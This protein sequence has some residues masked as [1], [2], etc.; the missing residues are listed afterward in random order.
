MIRAGAIGGACLLCL[1]SIGLVQGCSADP[2]RGYSF[3]SAHSDSIRTVAV[4]VFKNVTYSKTLEVQLTEAIISEIRRTTPWSVTSPE[5]ADA[6][7]TGTL[8]ES[9]MRAMS[10]G[11]QTGIVEQMAIKLTVDFDF[12]D[13]RTG[14][15]MVSRRR[16]SGVSS[17]V[18]AQPAQ[19]NLQTGQNAAV[20]ELAQD[21]VAELRAD[22]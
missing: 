6:V 7:L 22:W 21:I 9:S 19:E 18:P 20:Q 4:P 16:F 1:T 10:I 11:Q 13:N 5:A 8:T 15:D 14:K 17:F 2:K 12:T 3:S